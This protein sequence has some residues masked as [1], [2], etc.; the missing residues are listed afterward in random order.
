M[1]K[2]GGCSPATACW[3]SFP[4]AFKSS[5]PQR[6]CLGIEA[7]VVQNQGGEIDK[8]KAAIASQETECHRQAKRAEA[9]FNCLV[10]DRRA[11]T[12][13][14]VADVEGVTEEYLA[15]LTSS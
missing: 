3:D 10:D 5:K 8:L 12:N 7:V 14:T 9:L 2:E 1:R 6:S 15:I 4:L 13:R 11:G